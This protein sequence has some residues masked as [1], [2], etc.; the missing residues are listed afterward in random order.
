M[1]ERKF[2]FFSRILCNTLVGSCSLSLWPKPNQKQWLWMSVKN[3]SAFLVDVLGRLRQRAREMIKLEVLTRTWTQTRFLLVM[4]PHNS[5]TWYKK[6]GLEWSHNR[7]E[8]VGMFSYVTHR[9]QLRRALNDAWTTWCTLTKLTTRQTTTVLS[10]VWH[11]NNI[12][13]IHDTRL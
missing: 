1:V 8:N 12:W 2:L 6:N 11:P 10:T 3:F 9:L 7:P 4:F 13:E 5:A